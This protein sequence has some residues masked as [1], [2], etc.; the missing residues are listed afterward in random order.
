MKK[1]ILLIATFA[2][3]AF[4]AGLASA[5]SMHVSTGG[6]KGT[7]SA[8]FKQLAQ[9]CSAITLVEQNSSGSNENIDRLIG[10]QVNGAFVQTD[11]LFFRSRTE[12]LKNVKTLLALHPEEVHFLTPT[13]AKFKEG[14]MLGLGGKP[15]VFNTVSDLSGRGVGAAGGSVTTAKVIR[16]QSEI[17][18][19]VVEFADNASMLNALNEGTIAAGV[20]VGGSPM[21]DIAALGPDW[22]LL[23]FPES[24]QAKLKGVYRP[25]RLNYSKMNASGV[26]TIATDALF[27]TRE[28]KTP[29]MLDQLASF[30]ACAQTAIPELQETMGTH[31]KWQ[32]VDV[33]NEGK[34]NYYQLPAAAK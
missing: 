30:R 25:A 34:W 19:K 24:V 2:V 33:A 4:T 8:M 23:S 28:Y 5:Q 11:V 32:A 3:Y 12:D 18:F 7:Y 1:N 15:P 21:A 31:P 10:N 6:P 16:L 22:K 27:V 9:A 14:G 29:K 13:V 20:M 26:Q 17:D